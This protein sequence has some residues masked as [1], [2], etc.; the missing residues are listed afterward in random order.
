[1]SRRCR[2]LSA[3]SLENRKLLAAD[4]MVVSQ[5]TDDG[6]FI[7]PFDAVIADTVRVENGVTIIGST[8][9]GNQATAGPEGGGLWNDAG[10]S[11][12]VSR[13]TDKEI[14]DALNN[15]TQIT[16]NPIH[17]GPVN[18]ADA[19][20]AVMATHGEFFF[21]GS[22]VGLTATAEGNNKFFDVFFARFDKSM[23]K[24]AE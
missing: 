23:P 7:E 8:V 1:M 22:D 5:L 18:T 2:R 20:D 21:D 9:T 10:G 13:V 19:A 11:L 16:A 3:E 15:G 24:L 6:G 17:D 4:T 14:I 12:D